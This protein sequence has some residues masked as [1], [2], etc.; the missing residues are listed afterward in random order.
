MANPLAATQ[1]RF[2]LRETHTVHIRRRLEANPY[3]ISKQQQ[4]S[5]AMIG[6]IHSKKTG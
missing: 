2:P 4:E 1:K 5:E 6:T 3:L